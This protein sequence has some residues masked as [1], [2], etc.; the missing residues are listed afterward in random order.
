M[1]RSVGPR[2]PRDMVRAS[3][4]PFTGEFELVIMIKCDRTD[5]TVERCCCQPLVIGVSL[6]RCSDCED[7]SEKNAP[8]VCGVSENNT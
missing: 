8:S 3:A 6:C 1:L 7:M 4:R 2:A 5:V